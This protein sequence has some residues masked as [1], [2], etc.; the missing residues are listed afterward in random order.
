MNKTKNKKRGNIMRDLGIVGF[1]I[2]FAIWLV[3]SGYLV[4]LLSSLSNYVWLG[5]FV[6]GVFFTSIFTTVPAIAALG[7]IASAHPVWQVAL[8]GAL[9]A[10]VGDLLIFRYVEDELGE[11]L[12]ELL[13]HQHTS[14]RL[15]ALVRLPIVRF[16]SF[17]AGG[18]IIASP[19]PDELGIGL[20]SAVR[21]S[22][23]LLALCSFT[24]N[25]LGILMIGFVARAI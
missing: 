8:I 23:F 15:K 18:L 11:H 16:L 19:L 7:G 20:M 3:Q 10:V 2:I 9:G 21:L 22:P 5:S 17:F 25:F 14:K 13:S 6:A 4:H 12:A 1:S 24:F